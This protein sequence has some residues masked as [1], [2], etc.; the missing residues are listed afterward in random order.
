MLTACHRG[1]KEVEIATVFQF[2]ALSQFSYRHR[3]VAHSDAGSV[4]ASEDGFQFAFVHRAGFLDDEATAREIADI[5][6]GN[7][8][9]AV[10]IKLGNIEAL[11]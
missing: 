8:Q 9:M 11:L 10:L 2:Q 3:E 7:E 6:V 1:G 4:D 5:V